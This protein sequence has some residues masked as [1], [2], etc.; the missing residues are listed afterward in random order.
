MTTK[1]ARIGPILLLCLVCGPATA[2]ELDA[3]GALVFKGR[4]EGF[5]PEAG[6]VGALQGRVVGRDSAEFLDRE[7]L[8]RMAVSL[9]R[10]LE[11]RRAL[12]LAARPGLVSSLTWL[13][14]G[15][16]DPGHRVEVRLWQRAEGTRARASLVWWA[17]DRASLEE[18][19]LGELFNMG[20]LLLVPSGRATDDGW[21]ELTSGPVD[22]S[23]GGT[24]PPTLLVQD[25]LGAHD[26]S[27]SARVLLDALEVIDLGPEPVATAEACGALAGA[28]GPGAACRYGRCVD[29]AV[30]DGPRFANDAHR[31]QY[32]DRRAVELEL[33]EGHRA[34]RRNLARA[35]GDLQRLA[36]GP[37][38]PD[39][40]G[41]LALL[42][43]ALEDGHA[44]PPLVTGASSLG[45][46][47][48]AHLGAPD[49]LPSGPALAPLVY[50]VA[51]GH[52]ATAELRPGDVIV[53]VDG[54]S[55]PDWRARMR[56]RLRYAGQAETRAVAET[57]QV[58]AQAALAGSV[59]ELA[60]CPEEGCAAAGVASLT[61]DYRAAAAPLWQDILPAWRGASVP[62]D[63]RFSRPA[64]DAGA[65]DF[66]HAATASVAG[67][68]VLQINATVGG[69]FGDAATWKATVA[70]ALERPGPRV[71][72]DHRRGDGG[73]FQG[74]HYITRFFFE[75]NA[76]PVNVVFAVLGDRDLVLRPA[77]AECA[78]RGPGAVL[79]CGGT[80]WVTGASAAPDVPRPGAARTSRLAIL[81]GLDVSGNDWLTD[82]LRR[83]RRPGDGE[84]RVFGP[85]PTFG[86]FGEVVTL[87]VHRFGYDGPRLQ[88]T[89]GV[90]VFEPTDPLDEDLDGR[91]VAP[92]VV[93]YQKQSDAL[94][95][96]DT[97]VEE[98][99]RWLG[100]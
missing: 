4:G 28:C 98:A 36:D 14:D 1:R 39:F 17:G 37:Q 42:Y 24:L 70:E 21:E 23:L 60:R 82:H 67:A 85:A 79:E 61:V 40:W 91:G 54:L 66:S 16:V 18:G 29:A 100:Q 34:A 44:R 68:R 31:R 94:A 26:P 30:V 96:V 64:G 2:A 5:E 19:R 88:W 77:L 45:A 27:S 12:A 8:G 3:T 69:S 84:T 35:R 20:T 99:L 74:L 56:A 71:L 55:V 50:R 49:L 62:C 93:V 15:A 10:P 76:G 89:G 63:A 9:E 41:Q 48:C 65:G 32:L 83:R 22:F 58:L 75:P 86:A 97:Q 47:A 87:P 95:G 11:G 73:S 59:A 52:G 53:R 90:V 25:E 7:S 46:G 33:F 43:D 72:L 51:P 6:P 92:D 78:R 57:P 80:Q 81:T 13:L 38:P